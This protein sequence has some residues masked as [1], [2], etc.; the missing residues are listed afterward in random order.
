MGFGPRDLLE[1][2]VLVDATREQP[3][4]MGPTRTAGAYLAGVFAE[5]GPGSAQGRCALVLLSSPDGPAVTA[6]RTREALGLLPATPAL[7][8][9]R[10]FAGRGD[11]TIVSYRLQSGS[12]YHNLNDRY[13][14]SPEEKVIA[15]AALTGEATASGPVKEIGG[16][17][18]RRFLVTLPSRNPLLG[19]LRLMVEVAAR[20]GAVWAVLHSNELR[21]Y[22]GLSSLRARGTALVLHRDGQEWRVPIYE[23]TLGGWFTAALTPWRSA[24]VPIPAGAYGADLAIDDLAFLESGGSEGARRVPLTAA[25]LVPPPPVPSPEASDPGRPVGDRGFRGTP[26]R[27][28]TGAPV[29][30]PR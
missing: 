27:A 13:V 5:H 8:D 28:G 29:P 14:L 22:D 30:V 23:G 2:V 7:L 21:G 11:M 12:C 16:G 17:D 3:A 26:P 18:A 4:F 25:L 10:T 19:P 15:A 20:N 9:V 6:D 1:R 24:A